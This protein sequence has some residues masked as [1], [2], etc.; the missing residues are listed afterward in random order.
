MKAHNKASEWFD[1]LYQENKE[2]HENIPWARQAVNPLLQT[3]LESEREHNGTALVIGCGLGDDAI[4]LERAGYDVTAIDVSQTALD[5]A[6]ERFADSNVK[7]VKQDIF[8]YEAQ[9]D[10]VF[11]ALTIQSLPVEFRKKMISAVAHTVKKGGRLLLV[12]HKKEEDF[13]GPPWPL[14]QAEVD[15]FKAQGLH[16]LTH[17]L[18]TE[19]SKISNTRFRVL[20]EK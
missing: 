6:K 9:F 17:E 1:G 20:Y 14:T 11:E 7:F 2:T 18:H 16:E 8:E 10:F 4:A 13:D 15:L 5:L 12:A 3:Y 19:D